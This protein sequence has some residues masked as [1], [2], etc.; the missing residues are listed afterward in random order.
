MI[1]ALRE[2]LRNIYNELDD[3]ELNG[4]NQFDYSTKILSKVT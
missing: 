4:S 2:R 1:K 3:I